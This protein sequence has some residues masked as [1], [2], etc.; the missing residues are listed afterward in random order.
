MSKDLT[1]NEI[2]T[3]LLEGMFKEGQYVWVKCKV[4]NKDGK[5][6]LEVSSD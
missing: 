3:A 1:L 6:E 4:V 2:A 5:L